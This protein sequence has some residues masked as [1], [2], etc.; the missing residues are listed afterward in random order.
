MKIITGI[1]LALLIT[2]LYLIFI[3]HESW[4]I[5]SLFILYI[6]SSYFQGRR[7]LRHEEVDPHSAK[8][9]S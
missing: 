7:N 2:F 6:T 9:F 5:G 8:D 3:Q 1:Y 4:I